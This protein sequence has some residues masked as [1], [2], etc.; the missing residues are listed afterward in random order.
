[1]NGFPVG[2]VARIILRYG[3]GLAFGASV[4][5]QLVSNPDMVAVVSAAVAACV[6]GFYALAKKKGWKT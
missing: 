4:G 2:P 3:A 1:M 5:Q 6:E